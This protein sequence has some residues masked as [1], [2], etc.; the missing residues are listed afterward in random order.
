MLLIDTDFIL[1]VTLIQNQNSVFQISILY[2]IFSILHT[3]CLEIWKKQPCLQITSS[4][5]PESIFPGLFSVICFAWGCPNRENET[6]A[7]VSEV[8]CT[9]KRQ[10]SKTK[11]VS[12]KKEDILIDGK[13]VVSSMLW[14]LHRLRKTT[15]LSLCMRLQ[16]RSNLILPEGEYQSS[17]HCW[18]NSD[19]VWATYFRAVNSVSKSVGRQGQKQKGIL[20]FSLSN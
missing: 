14:P 13:W 11:V 3:R 12:W 5:N 15:R 16:I 6:R 20:T 19:Y 7:V 8:I 9:P 17:N 10:T 2:A 18:Y 1:C 4:R